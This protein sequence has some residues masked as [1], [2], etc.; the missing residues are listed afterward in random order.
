MY[1]SIPDGDE[2]DGNLQLAA[3]NMKKQRGKLPTSVFIN[4]PRPP[5]PRPL[6][7]FKSSDVRKILMIVCGFVLFTIALYLVSALENTSCLGAPYL[8]ATHSQSRNILKYSRDGCLL[9]EKVL[10]GTADPKGEL[11]GMSLGTYKGQP[12]LF[13]ANAHESQSSVMIYGD[14]LP[15]T[16]MR[17]FKSFA[18][19]VD[20]NPGA[21]HTYGIAFDKLGNLYASFQHTD[22]VLHFNKDTFEPLPLPANFTRFSDH[23]WK[24]HKDGHVYHDDDEL[25]PLDSYF[26]GTFVQF[27]KPNTHSKSSGLYTQ[28]VR[29]LRWVKNSTELWI[30][31]EDIK[32]VFIVGPA[33]RLI[34]TIYVRN[35]I[36]LYT[37][38]ELPYMFVGSKNGKKSAVYAIDKVTYEVVKSYSL[39]G[40]H[41]PTG[42]VAY[43]DE[44]YVGDQSKDRVVVFNM[45]TTRFIR[46][47]L[48]FDKSKI[49]DK[50]E[51]I[52]LSPC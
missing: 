32:A 27:G 20:T 9:S 39:I 49:H 43:G 30:A 51:Q 6:S 33:G 5:P 48:V 50:I 36:G 15:H 19:T 46:N 44:L 26:P 14:C 2:E 12:T 28:G 21:Q 25:P 11:R 13:V 22:V 10:W 42:I 23:E 47:A 31:N 16:S 38:D 40:M 29:D 37:T 45:T 34:K 17:S 7:Y 35:P 18:I 52:L 1:T 4:K 8:Y 41:H 24:H 3:M